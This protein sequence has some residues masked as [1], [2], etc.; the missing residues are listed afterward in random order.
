ERGDLAVA[1]ELEELAC[2][3]VCE[4]GFGHS[5]DEGEVCAGDDRQSCGSLLVFP[6]LRCGLRGR[7]PGRC[8]VLVR[9]GDDGCADAEDLGVCDVADVECAASGAVLL[10]VGEPGW[11]VEDA[12]CTRG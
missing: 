10:V 1:G 12:S 4:D 8:E 11:G 6:C 5:V 3:V 7:V 9:V 2:A